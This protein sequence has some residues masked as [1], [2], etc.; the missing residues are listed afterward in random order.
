[1]QFRA[2][3]STISRIAIT[4]LARSCIFPRV[5][6]VWQFRL[7]SFDVLLEV[8][9]RVDHH[10]CS[11]RHAQEGLLA[12]IRVARLPQSIAQSSQFRFSVDYDLLVEVQVLF[13]FAAVGDAPGESR[14]HDSTVLLT[15]PIFGVS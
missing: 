7:A 6:T 12:S 4:T 1:M 3:S 2:Y 15:Q 10:I 9:K 5:H 11:L 8:V 14:G 13:P